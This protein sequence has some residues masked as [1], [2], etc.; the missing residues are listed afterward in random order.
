MMETIVIQLATMIVALT[1]FVIP[2][3]NETV[4]DNNNSIKKLQDHLYQHQLTSVNGMNLMGQETRDKSVLS[5][6]ISSMTVP[7]LHFHLK[8][9]LTMIILGLKTSTLLKS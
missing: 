8:L 5:S 9:S 7:T 2:D 4:L 1:I 6:I 3:D